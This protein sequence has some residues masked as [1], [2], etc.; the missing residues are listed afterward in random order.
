MK[1]IL[2]VIPLFLLLTLLAGCGQRTRVEAQLDTLDSILSIPPDGPEALVD[3]DSIFHQ[4]DSLQ[5]SVIGD[6][7]L[8]ARWNLLYTMTEDK[9]DRPLLLDLRIR[10]SY[11]YY[12]AQTQDGTRGDSILLHRFAQSCFYL[13]AH[14]YQCD[15]LARMEQLMHRSAEVSKSCGDH[16]TAYLALTYLSGALAW[17][18]P[19]TAIPMADDALK[20]YSL[21]HQSSF[22]NQISLLMNLGTCWLCSEEKDKSLPYYEKA[23]DLSVNH[24]D[25]LLYDKILVDK[26]YYYYLT[27]YKNESLDCLNRSSFQNINKTDFSCFTTASFIYS[28][29]G[30]I[31]QAKYVLELL[32]SELTR[33][34]RFEKYWLL[35]RISIIQK[36]TAALSLGDSVMKHV[37]LMHVTD[38][39]EN[40]EYFRLNAESEREKLQAEKKS[41]RQLFS[42]ISI[43]ILLLSFVFFAFYVIHQRNRRKSQLMELELARNK[44]LADR[45]QMELNFKESELVQKNNK[46]KF[47]KKY[48]EKQSESI[49]I[50]KKENIKGK[51]RHIDDDDWKSLEIAIDDVCHNFVSRLRTSFPKMKESAIRLCMLQRIQLTNRQMANIFFVEPETIKKR[52]QRLK[53]IF[54]QDFDTNTTFEEVIEKI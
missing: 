47:L 45:K 8:E 41:E 14:Y 7:A 25:S 27:G 50:F 32:G 31:D 10:P 1:H 23:L 36:D 12:A 40:Y 11:D 15:S 17:S 34:Q 53:K 30:H 43:G 4:L 51:I 19:E 2:A 35:Q 42:F 44:M 6:D 33:K 3:Y 28:Q 49:A 20:E 37:N 26:A 22:F 29:Y 16:Y 24:A 52:K 5:P 54:F 46:L 13:G 48:I 21:S 9:S 18:N 39:Y 38:R